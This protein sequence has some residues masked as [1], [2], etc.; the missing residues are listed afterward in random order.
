MDDTTKRLFSGHIRIE[1][2]AEI[3]ARTVRVFLNSTAEGKKKKDI[4]DA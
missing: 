2:I 3:P 4:G 1:D